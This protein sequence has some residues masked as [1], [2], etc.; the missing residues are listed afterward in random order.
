[1]TTVP[2]A[3]LNGSHIARLRRAA[4]TVIRREDEIRLRLTGDDQSPV[5]RAT[6][7]S[8]VF[9]VDTMTAPLTTPVLST[10]ASPPREAVVTAANVH[11]DVGPRAA[12]RAVLRGATLHVSRGEW[13]AIVGPSGCG[14]SSLLSI[15]GGLSTP[16]EGHVL[17]AGTEVNALSDA[18]RARFRRRHIGFVF[19]DYNLIDDLTVLGNVELPLLLTGTSSRKARRRAKALLAQL[20]LAGRESEMPGNLSGGEQQRVAIGRALV[21]RPDVILADEPTG[22]LD[23][24]AAK[25]VVELLAEAR[26]AGQTIVMVTH[27]LDV[28]A[29]ADRTVHMRDGLIDS[30]TAVSR[31]GAS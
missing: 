19:Q 4:R 29:A 3:D 2:I 10:F 11:Y 20:G 26:R 5:R 15:I 13:V 22:A 23:S 21:A 25:L 31:G 6:P 8:R 7:T 28:A 24:K 14:K 18:R 17:V 12:R 9:T 1:M 30:R 27:D 16:D